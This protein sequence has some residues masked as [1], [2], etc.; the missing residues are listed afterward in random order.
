MGK[1]KQ[2][3]ADALVRQKRR[4]E[5]AA[6]RRVTFAHPIN[7]EGKNDYDTPFT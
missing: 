2:P 4:I 5:A 1:T 7:T 3:D 6:R